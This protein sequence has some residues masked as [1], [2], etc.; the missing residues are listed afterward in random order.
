[1]PRPAAAREIPPPLE[2][3]CLKALWSLREANV[4][5]VQQAVA[6]T[7]ELAYTTVMTVLD[8][9]ARKGVVSRRKLGRAF[10]YAPRT[11]PD[12]IRRLALREFLDSY[13][14]GSQEQLLAFLHGERTA[15]P[16]SSG[17]G[18]EPRLDTALL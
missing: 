12:V 15:A 14:E 4:K 5:S 1:M 13:F 8:R 17:D 16:V 11:P 9:L 10:I 2:L 7:K 6:P 18:E 3:L